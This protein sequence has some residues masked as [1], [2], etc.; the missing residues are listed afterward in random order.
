MADNF[1]IPQTGRV[2]EG[3]KFYAVPSADI[4]AGAIFCPYP[5]SSA[6]FGI[7]ET[8]VAS[9]ELG[10]FSK[11]GTFAFTA[12]DGWTSAAGQPVYYTPST[13]GTGTITATKS[14]ST[15]FIG[16]EVVTP[17]VPLGQIWVDIQPCAEVPGDGYSA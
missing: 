7:A 9:G 3:G 12:P 6:Q 16:F 1:G 8:P 2:Y 14:A 17:S 15:I 11:V 5:A 13:Q 10:A 4:A